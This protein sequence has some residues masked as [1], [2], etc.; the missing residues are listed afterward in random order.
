MVAITAT[1][2]PIPRGVVYGLLG[3]IGLAVGW[4]LNLR[5][6]DAD[7]GAMM[8]LD[9]NNVVARSHTTCPNSSLMLGPTT[10]P[11]ASED[12]GREYSPSLDGA[13]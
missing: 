12:E 9:D 3:G 5:V 2:R 7:E 8:N 1:T 13:I 10:Q 6:R 11:R 4:T